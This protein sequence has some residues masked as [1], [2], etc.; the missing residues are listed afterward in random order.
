MRIRSKVKG[1]VKINMKESME[2]I[3]VALMINRNNNTNPTVY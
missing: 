1:A 2:R 3:L